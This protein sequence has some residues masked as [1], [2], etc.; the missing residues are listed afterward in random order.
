MN[1]KYT[2]AEELRNKIL[3]IGE[4]LNIRRFVRYEGN[5]VAYIH[6]GGR[7]GVLVDF[8][9]DAQVVS[10]PAFPEIGKDVAMQVA[11]LNPLY[12]DRTAVTPDILEKEKEIL[13]AQI[14]NDEKNAKKP[15]QIIAKMVE[16]KLGNITRPTAL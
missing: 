13:M 16:G 3:T 15:D 2:V 10:N 6:G 8:E 14:K 5:V 4:N 11:A 9:G 1:D 7:I 12:L